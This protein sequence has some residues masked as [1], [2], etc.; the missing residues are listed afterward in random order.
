SIYGTSAN[1]FPYELPWGVITSKPGKLYLHVFQWPRNGLEIYGIQGKVERASL[2]ANHAAV[3]FSQKDDKAR[4]YTS[5]VLKLGPQAPDPNDSVIV[6][7]FAGKAEA[8]P[9]LQQ[10]PDGGITLPAHLSELHKSPESGA[11]LDS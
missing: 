11:R 2:L 5:L 6:L 8:D 4:G 3:H 7:E 10:Q 9:S 1:P